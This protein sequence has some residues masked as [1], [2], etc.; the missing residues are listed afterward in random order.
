[1]GLAGDGEL[2]AAAQAHEPY[3]VGEVLA[4]EVVYDATDGVTAKLDGR[5]LRIS[6]A[7]GR[8]GT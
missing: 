1:M 3:L 7:S 2:I 4:T 8:A 5:E 6:I